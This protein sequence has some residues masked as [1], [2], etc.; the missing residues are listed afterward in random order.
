MKY[1]DE[2]TYSPLE[3][4]S[5]CYAASKRNK[6]MAAQADTLITLPAAGAARHKPCDMLNTN[7]KASLTLRRN[8][9]NESKENHPYIC[10][11][12]P[13]AL[14]LFDRNNIL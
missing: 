13:Y 4:T 6:W 11:C 14:C 12:L 7:K 1:Y 3:N 10:H 5:P 9:E 2:T 8:Q